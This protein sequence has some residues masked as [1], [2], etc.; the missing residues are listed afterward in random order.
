MNTKGTKEVVSLIS[1]NISEHVVRL[2]HDHSYQ[3]SPN[4]VKSD[5]SRNKEQTQ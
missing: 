4:A 2:I 3:Y 5:L 1:K